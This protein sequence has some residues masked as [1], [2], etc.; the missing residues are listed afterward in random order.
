VLYTS[1]YTDDTIVRD[2]VLEA[3][4]PFL[5]KPV[6]AKRAAAKS[7]RLA[8]SNSAS[9]VGRYRVARRQV[10]FTAEVSRS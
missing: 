1:G 3:G 5:Q 8:A 6:H 4:M 9:N 10:D 2:E 7:A